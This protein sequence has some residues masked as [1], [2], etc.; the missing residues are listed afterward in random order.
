MLRSKTEKIVAYHGTDDGEIYDLEKDPNEFENLWNRPGEQD[1][2]MRLLKWCF[3]T[4]V[5][6]MDPMPPRLG[7]F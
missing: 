4:S 3:D 5:F 1:R 7:P 6:T 2:K